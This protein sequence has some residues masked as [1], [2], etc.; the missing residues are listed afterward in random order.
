MAVIK[1]L[2]EKL[3]KTK[4]GFVDK[5]NNLVLSSKTID[6]SFY[7][8]LEEILVSSD[9]GVNT[10]VELIE[11]IKLE[12]KQRKIK[13]PSEVKTLLQEE[14][15]NLLPKNL[16]LDLN[17]KPSII[18][19]VGVNGVGKTTTIGKL[20]H[21]FK[22]DDKS[23]LLAAGDTFRAAAIEQLDIW[24]KN[25]GAGIVK[26]NQGADPAAVAYDAVQ[27]AKNRDIDV[28]I[29]DT[30][31]RLQTKVNLMKEL[32]KIRRVIQKDLSS[33]PHETLLVL[34]ATT[35]Q[36]AISQAKLFNESVP[37]TGIILT[38]LDG[39]AK[40]GVIFGI[41]SELGIPVKFIGIGEG[42]DDLRPFEPE[43]FVKAL[44]EEE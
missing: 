29:V 32:E 16:E 37:L 7:E 43:N 35:G 42:I 19:I 12:V 6:E 10:S 13:D 26:Y 11:K 2:K 31:G 21:K 27:A 9:V 28:V 4:E 41:S 34:D 17:S 38:K 3:S 18:M 24:A 30:A 23:T 36:N 5:V 14:M 22:N 20:A 33:S 25:S 39:T 40:G 15:I 44:F 1:N 8:E